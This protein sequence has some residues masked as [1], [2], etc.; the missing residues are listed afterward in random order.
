MSEIRIDTYSLRQLK[1]KFEYR[2]FAIPEIQRQYVWNKPRVCKLMD[3][4]F[5]GYP[6]GISL[7]WTAKYSQAINI[8]PNNKTIIP[9]FNKR[10]T[11]S[12]LIIDGQQRL[13]TLYGVLYEVEEKPESNSFINFKELFFDCRKKSDK[14]FV[15]S[16]RLQD[17]SDGYIRLSSLLNNPP[18]VLKSK[19][20]LKKWEAAEAEKC[21]KA[22]HSYK[23]YLLAFEG[24]DYD[25]A[26]E[27][28]IRI[29]SAGMTVSRADT[30]FAKA[31]DVDLRDHMLDTRRGLTHGFSDI[32]V[33]ALQNTLGL[34][35][36]ATQIGNKGFNAF[37][38]KIE[39]NKKNNKEF[40]KIWKKLQY[41]Y[42]ET[43]DFLVKTLNIYD[44]E[45]LP[46][47]NIYSMLS[48]FFFLT[49]SRA[50]PAQIREIKKWFWHTA[51]GD[52][53]SGADFNRNI[54]EDIKFFQ[55][56]AKGNN[57]KYPISDKA[58]PVEFI[59]ANYRNA[60][61]SATKAY[62]ILLGYKKP[63]YLINGT[64]MHLEKTSAISNRKDRHHIFPSAL[65]RRKGIKPKWINSIA[66]ICYLEADENQSISDSHP[67]LYLEDYKRH[68]HFG[69]VMKSHLISYNSNS[70]VWE[71]NVHKAF[72]AF[73]NQ[74]GKTIISEIEKLAGANIFDK[75]DAIRRI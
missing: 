36:G 25:D 7:V 44:I 42:E 28:F 50:R 69:K 56:L 2:E 5:R 9:P 17:G 49:Q 31:S 57:A 26:K 34:A 61:S 62:F 64:E 75:F 24:L 32:S 55:R 46:S 10:A 14:R 71:H 60:V 29:N 63:R 66:N 48:Y 33:D 47:Q 41:G 35:Y 15:F 18:S 12:D 1:E 45:L 73:I 11:K 6:I 38:N 68:K 51:C 16:K 72:L 19:L 43:S 65:L 74:R 30:L 39:R 8:R 21:Y 58:S 40:E 59:K 23:F 20:K 37:L 52:R 70:P 67:R 4:I 27:I 54:P 13:S 53:Y 22:F 3:S